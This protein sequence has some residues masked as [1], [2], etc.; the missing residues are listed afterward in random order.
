MRTAPVQTAT[1]YVKSV[2]DYGAQTVKTVSDYSTQKVNDLCN[3][4]G[5]NNKNGEKEETEKETEGD[6]Q[7][8]W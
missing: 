4:V 1:D 2:S 5:L 8:G 3:Q 7:A 6:I